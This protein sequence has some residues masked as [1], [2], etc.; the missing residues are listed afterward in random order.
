MISTYTVDDL[1]KAYEYLISFENGLSNIEIPKLLKISD[2]LLDFRKAY[3]TS[4]SL[5]FENGLSNIEIPKL[6]KISDILLDFRK[7][8]ITS[9][10]LSFAGQNEISLNNGKNS[11]NFRILLLD[12]Y[13]KPFKKY[14]IGE[15][16]ENSGEPLKSLRNKV[17]NNKEPLD[18]KD[19]VRILI[20]SIQAIIAI[21]LLNKYRWD[22]DKLYETINF[23][24]FKYRDLEIQ[25][26]WI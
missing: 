18:V 4:D 6:L 12:R 25:F 11:Y 16:V 23:L 1:N 24:G 17:E 19:L 26:P 3:I 13:T 15:W 7:A 14:T 5:S 2:I 9:D 10:S 22:E 21:E 8:Y 20:T